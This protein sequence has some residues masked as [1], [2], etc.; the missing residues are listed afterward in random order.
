MKFDRDDRADASQ[1]EDRR[2][3]G[4]PGGGYGVG[5]GLG[6]VGVIVVVIFKLLSGD[7]RGAV[8]VAVDS[9]DPRTAPQRGQT[10]AAPAG[11][12]A[13]SGSCEGVSSDSDPAKFIVCVETNVQSFWTKELPR[14]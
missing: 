3:G 7:T 1:V 6:V 8:D 12:A 9:T 11:S 14:S 4:F 13:I 2:G 5:G 10:Q